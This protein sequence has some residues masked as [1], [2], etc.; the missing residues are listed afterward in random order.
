[1]GLIHCNLI[2]IERERN[3]GDREREMGIKK[4]R[5]GVNFYFLDS[6]DN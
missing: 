1:M 4:G 3:R 2:C 5:G 6:L